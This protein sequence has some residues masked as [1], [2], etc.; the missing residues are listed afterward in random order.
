M[1]IFL[2][3][4]IAVNTFQDLNAQRNPE[5]IVPGFALL[6]PK[7]TYSA[8]PCI[9][10]PHPNSATMRR[11]GNGLAEF[12]ARQLRGIHFAKIFTD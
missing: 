4:A 7:M 6:R 11:N 2:S 8:R 10:L 1:E 12:N 5:Q 9:A 3:F